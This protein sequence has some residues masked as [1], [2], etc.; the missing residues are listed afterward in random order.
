MCLVHFVCEIAIYGHNENVKKL[1]LALEKKPPNILDQT[2]SK[3]D[4]L[5]LSAE[6]VADSIREPKI[7]C[8]PSKIGD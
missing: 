4:K 5:M 1:S 2:E 7:P 3:S 8:Q 6:I